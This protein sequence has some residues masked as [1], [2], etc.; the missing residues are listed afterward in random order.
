MHPAQS[1][2]EYAWI[3]RVESLGKNKPRPGQ[4]LRYLRI[5]VAALKWFIVG[6]DK[7]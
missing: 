2:S 3:W 6:A 5:L 4:V 7:N 1:A